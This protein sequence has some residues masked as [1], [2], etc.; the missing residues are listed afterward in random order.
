MPRRRKSMRPLRAVGGSTSPRAATRSTFG[1][2]FGPRGF[3]EVGDPID[4]GYSGSPVFNETGRLVG[5]IFGDLAE[6][7]AKGYVVPIQ[8]VTELFS[9][10]NART[11]YCRTTSGDEPPLACVPNFV[12]Y[13]VSLEKDNHSGVSSEA[14][15]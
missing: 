4:P 11:D 3:W 14:K 9:A 8:H 1:T 2:R 5:I 13:P 10:A 7:K 12:D 6:A 15:R